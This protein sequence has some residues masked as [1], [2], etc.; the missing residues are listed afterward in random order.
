[1]T[2]INKSAIGNGFRKKFE[3]WLVKDKRGGRAATRPGMA[4]LWCL[5]SENAEQASPPL[6]DRTALVSR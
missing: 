5:L 2:I 6:I 4:V 3:T 1:M